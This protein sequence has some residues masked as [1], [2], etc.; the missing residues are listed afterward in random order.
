MKVQKII[1]AIILCL[2]TMICQAQIRDKVSIGLADLKSTKIQEFDR[3]HWLTDYRISE[4]GNPELPIYR[5]S[6]VIPIDAKVTGVTFQ[7]QEKRLFKRDV[8]IYPSQ[9]PIPVGYA[10]DIAFTLP[11]KR[12]YESD[13]PFPGK[14]YDIESDDIIYG[15]RV[16]TIRIYPFEY[17]PKNRIL[18]YYPNLEYTVEYESGANSNVIRTETQSVLRADLCKTFIIHLV[19][20]AS[21]VE[22]FGSNARSLTN[23][24]TVVQQNTPGLRSQGVSILD[25]IVP[26]YIIITCDSL[27][28]AFQPLVDWKTKKG[29]FTIVITVEEIKANYVGSDLAEKI[30]NYLLEAHT[31]WGNGLYILLG[32]DINII[33]SRMVKGV[34]DNLQYPTDKYYSTSSDA[35]W[36]MNVNQTF[37]GSDSQSYINFLGRIPMSNTQEIGIIISKITAYEKADNL[38][39]LNYLNN[40]LYAD[41]YLSIDNGQLYD[42][43][44]SYIKSYAVNNAPNHINK[45]ICDNAN[46]SGDYHKYYSYGS[47]IYSSC[48]Q[49]TVNGDIELNR[50]NFLSCLNTGADLGVGKFH[51][52]YHMDHSSNGSMNTSGQ[53][54]GESINELDIDNLT[55]GTSWQILMSG[56]CNPDIYVGNQWQSRPYR[57]G[58]R[59]T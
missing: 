9:P 5:V 38:G 32:G 11:D 58:Q 26:E 56:G 10:D 6:Y 12:I 16:V 42:F 46:C 40:N 44:H 13:A 33:P 28:P 8:Y 17:V 18:N 35:D 23:G 3:I 48:T 50:D 7:S 25:E 4:E 54:K 27:K 24:R 59:S 57:M 22:Q 49:T 41:A 2:A 19:K 51:F 14:L 43:Y 52:I 15:Y 39:D 21:D 53:D 45:Y 1:Y 31:K 29:I 34:G 47:K 36:I 30:K 55:N 37:T 20:N